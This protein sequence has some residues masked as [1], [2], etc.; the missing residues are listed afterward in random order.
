MKTIKEISVSGKRVFI[1][2]D[3]N[4]PLDEYQ[5]ITDDSRI[6]AVLPTL[7]YALDN[8]AKLIIASHLG[9]PKG[10]V[11]PEFSLSPVA[12]RLGRLLEKEVRMAPD[13]IGADIKTMVSGMT[14]G[15]V[16]L[17]E[18]LRFH[19]GE[20]KNDDEFA[21]E[22]AAICDIY[23]NDAFAVSH[24]KNASVVAITKFVPV[25]VAG[26]LLQKEIDYFQRAMADPQR[27]LV[28]IVGGSKVS[29]KIGALENM[30]QHVD[31]FVIGGAMA[32]T[33]LKSR[34]YG[35]GTS[36]IEEDLIDVARSVMQKAEEK[37][38]KFYLPVD[39]VAASSFDSKAE[40]KIVPVQEIPSSWMALD[41]GPATS[42]LFS[43]VLHDAKTIVWN[44]PLG[45]FEMDAFSRGTI[46]MAHSVANSYA[47]SI[48]GGGDTDAAIHKAGESDRITY[49]STGGGAFLCLL[50]GKTLPAVAALDEAEAN[51]P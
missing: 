4:V 10:K 31:K 9:R 41:I 28:A 30:L 7:K 8:R 21:K 47:L 23:V 19:P 50:E 38:I 15:D 17:L 20:E 32:N 39:A 6:R 49:I 25:S 14:E 37:G 42:L 2:V 3:F 44:G 16:L 1:R 13:C 24:R 29:S 12:K 26:F 11:V 35:M 43:E 18:N 33:F 48:V 36:S 40:V 22:L 46:A 45:V 51:I 27:P 34:G 5:N